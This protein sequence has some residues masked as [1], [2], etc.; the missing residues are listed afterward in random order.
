MR[1]GWPF[2]IPAIPHRGPALSASGLTLTLPPVDHREAPAPPARRM[3]RRAFRAIG[4]LG[5]GRDSQRLPV[6]AWHPLAACRDAGIPKVFNLRRAEKAGLRIPATYWAPGEGLEPRD[7]REFPDLDGL[8]LPCIVRSAS[9]SEDTRITSNAGQFASV[10]VRDARAFPRAVG[11]VLD[12]LRDPSGTPRGAVFVQPLVEATR[13]GVTFF[14]GF[15]FEETSSKGGNA[16]LTSGLDRG[17]V[18]RGHLGRGDARSRFLA[19]VH[20]HFGGDLDIEWAIPASGPDR[21]EWVVLQVR[22]ALFPVRRCETLSLA[23]HKEIVGDLPSPWMAGVLAEVRHPVLR[24]YAHIEPAMRA[25]RE[26]YAVEV[27]ERAWLNFSAFYR[28]MDAWGLPRAMVT[29]GLG[30][31]P[32]GPEDEAILPG[33]LA[34]SL[35]KL[36]RVAMANF[37]VWGAIA[38]GLRRLD[39]EIAGARTLGDLQRVNVRAFEFSVETNFAIMSVLAVAGKLRRLLGVTR[40]ARVIT[41]EMMAEYAEI[42]ARAECADRLAGLDAW[43]ARYGH[44]GPLESD[45]RNPRFAEMRPQLRSALERGPSAPPKPAERPGLLARLL[46]PLFLADELRETYRDRL[47]I[48]WKRLRERILEEAGKAVAAGHLDDPDDAFF[49]RSGDLIAPP[50]TWRERVADRKLRRRRAESLVLPT[51]GRRDRLEALVSGCE[52]V[53]AGGETACFAGIGLGAGVV[54]G[55]VVLGRSVAEILGR[56]DVPES[57]VLV[58]ETLEPSWA[59]VFPRFAAVVA[60]LGGELSHAA[61]LL[62]EAAIPS[63]VNARGVARGL[64]DGDR[65][66]VDAGRGTVAR[67]E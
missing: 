8:T 23:N 64:R 14:D 58:A 15:Y 37:A 62:R 30:G 9:R 33:R 20:R 2:P 19:E 41:Q 35:P 22:P 38:A 3:I 52:P 1:R 6:S 63:V 7:A 66:R 46:H 48:R 28:M 29:E 40:S 49:L 57:P 10:V 21:G 17:T 34:R 26:P 18:V 55:T 39:R 61:I 67:A 65:V 50:G 44:R 56:G 51:T 60:D 24:R 25:W 59:V 16:A 54:E 45:P 47:M 11:E 43:L 32:D 13:A 4:L 5:R 42:A 12:S 36:A 27:A 31:A 53:E